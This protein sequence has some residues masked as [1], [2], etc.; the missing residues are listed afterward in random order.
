MNLGRV[1]LGLDTLTSCEG[2]ESILGH[3]AGLD[4]ETDTIKGNLVGC[5][6]RIS[7]FAR[8]KALKLEEEMSRYY[9]QS[10]HFSQQASRNCRGMMLGRIIDQNPRRSRVILH[11]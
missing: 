8:P 3:V 4:L 7:L 1:K 2:L 10:E 5:V 6:Q 9:G 11:A